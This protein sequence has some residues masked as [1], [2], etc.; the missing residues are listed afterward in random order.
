MAGPSL[1]TANMREAIDPKDAHK[2]LVDASGRW[3]LFVA[4][5]QQQG[6]SARSG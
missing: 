4:I 1:R 3:K 5:G 2:W 6:D